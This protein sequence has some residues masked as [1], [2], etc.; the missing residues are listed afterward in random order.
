MGSCGLT[1]I[2]YDHKLY[3]ANCGDSEAIAVLKDSDKKVIFKDL[4]TRLSVN[5]PL[6]RER[7]KKQFPDDEDIVVE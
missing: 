5:N 1:V 2:I 6:E 4:N 7:L 3:V